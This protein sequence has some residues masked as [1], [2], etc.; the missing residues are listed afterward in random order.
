MVQPAKEI[1]FEPYRLDCEAGQLWQADRVVELQA[2]PLAV[3]QYLAERP[4]LVVSKEELLQGVWEDTYVTRTTLK[5]CI[6]TIREALGDEAQQSRY[7]ET[8]GREGYRFIGTEPAAEEGL[9]QAL[10]AGCVGR[11]EE[12][13]H[14]SGWLDK[15]LQGERQVVLVTGEAGIGKTTVVDYFLTT[16]QETPAVWIGR[17]Q[18][19]EQYGTGEA[20]LPILEALGQLSQ[21]AAGDLLLEILRQHAPTWLAQLPSL[22]GESEREAIHRQVRGAT[23]E[24]MLREMAEAL[25]VLTATQSLLLILED[26]HW[27][28][29]STLELLS[30][31]AQRRQVAQLMVVGT[32]RPTDVIVREHPLREVTQELLAKRLCVE[33][34]LE[35]LT[36]DA[37]AEYVRS[38]L[39]GKADLTQLGPVIHQRTE[40]NALFMVNVVDH[41]V[42]EGV[43]GGAEEE[44]PDKGLA[45]EVRGIIPGGLQQLI[46]KQIERLH[47]EQQ[48]ALEVASVA[49]SEFPV[50]SVAAGLSADCDEIEELCEELASRG[51]FIEEIGFAEWPDGTFSG[52]YRFLHALYQNVFYRRIGEARRVRLH[53]VVG[54]REETGYGDTA[55]ERAAALARHFAQGRDLERAWRYS[56]QAGEN[57]ILRNA[58][59]EAVGHFTQ[60]L[61]LLTTLPDTPE[62]LQGE[63]ALQMDL[64]KALSATKGYAVPEV[65]RAYTRALELIPN[66]EQ[67]SQSFPVLRG[68]SEF[69]DLRGDFERASELSEQLLNFAQRHNDAGFLVE[70]HYLMGE[71]AW[72]QG[73]F[74]TARTHFEQSLALYD[75]DKHGE[76][77]F[78]Y[79]QDPAVGVLSDYA[80]VLWALGYPAQ[81]FERGKEAVQRAH[82]VTHPFSLAYARCFSASLHQMR[83]EW[84]AVQ[85]QAQEA[86]TIAT[87]Y[88][89]GHWLVMGTLLHSRTLV[90]QGSVKEGL[91]QL[92]QGMTAHQD[93]G[94]EAGA[95]SFLMTL[96]EVYGKAGQTEDG[97]MMLEAGFELGRSNGERYCEPEL[98]RLKGELLLQSQAEAAEDCFHKALDVAQQQQAK[99]WELR[100]A[101][102][103]SRLW[104]QQG[105]KTEARDLLA[106]VYNWFTEGFDTKDWQEAKALLTQLSA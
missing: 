39:S 77:A 34:P 26:L 10:A 82:E 48:R 76:H 21:G 43:V 88:G 23:R 28:D 86:I 17:G 57:T 78:L 16:V 104:Q 32:Y 103:L 72:F 50:A 19:L 25:E 3:L 80:L 18:C 59:Q 13:H 44:A 51:Q 6:R 29:V 14:L 52:Q 65:E 74:L 70:A 73:D 75:S 84:P 47:I 4:G 79:G 38:R 27:S 96:G 98:Y 15:A 102:S 11:E 36:Q 41:L 22:L 53:R 61:D 95:S 60:A 67:S 93:S 64:G 99:S 89:F 30:Y 58:P 94:A 8:V 40:G 87:E 33:L 54:E 63:L 101:L 91:T 2:R 90:E 92:L 106:P 83:R 68:L 100:A 9:A 49:G 81:A 62:H 7:L 69:Y 1:I 37:V 35:L 31:L 55:G 66:L 42:E 85:E 56:Q 12:L 46:D 97:L 105:K 5:V 45:E 20:Y 24:R 71:I